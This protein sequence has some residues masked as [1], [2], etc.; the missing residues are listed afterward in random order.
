MKNL[1]VKNTLILTAITVIA[2][3]CLGLVYEI[4]KEPIA[5]AQESAKQEA[6]QEVFA[7]ADTFETMEGFVIAEMD[8]N[9]IDEVVVA[10]NGTEVLGYVITVTNNE[11]YG[12]SLTFT[13]GICNDGTINGIS[14]LTLSE[15]AGLGMNASTPD[16]KDQFA[17]KSVESFE[18]TKTG[19]TSENQIDALS[20]ATI[21]STAVTNGVNAGITYF[22]DTLGGAGNE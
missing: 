16:F 8:S 12:G 15:T 19:S 1:I 11:A 2:G 20:G 18:V 21:T 13:M 22:N 9:S 14:F 7:S 5:A 4:T 17:D 3:M 10:M 6:Y